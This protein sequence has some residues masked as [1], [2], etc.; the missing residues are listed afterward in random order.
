MPLFSSRTF[1][2]ELFLYEISAAIKL[3]FCLVLIIVYVKSPGI[4]TFSPFFKILFST[5]LS[6]A[7]L[8]FCINTIPPPYTASIILGYLSHFAAIVFTYS[9]PARLGCIV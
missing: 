8:Y 5:V 2:E 1:C 4:I 6:S 3:L 9:I 7:E